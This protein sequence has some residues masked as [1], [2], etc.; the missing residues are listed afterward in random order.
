[1]LVLYIMDK[2]ILLHSSVKERDVLKAAVLD[3]VQVVDVDSGVSYDDT[4]GGMDLSS[5]SSLALVYHNNGLSSAPFFAGLTSEAKA[6]LE[7]VE[8]ELRAL[9]KERHD[10]MDIEI[11]MEMDMKPLTLED[12]KPKRKE[13]VEQVE[14][15]AVDAEKVKELD[16]KRKTLEAR[17]R[18]LMQSSGCYFNANMMKLLGKWSSE[19][20]EPKQLDILT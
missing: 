16:E 20:T 5:V 1:M 9:Y 14:S 17:K 11:V 8:T 3:S 19:N 4:V 18:E 2:L 10:L 12:G 7:S 13:P 6:E 15:S